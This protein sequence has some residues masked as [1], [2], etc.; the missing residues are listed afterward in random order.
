MSDKTT[1]Y[2]FEK[3]FRAIDPKTLLSFF[4]VDSFSDWIQSQGFDQLEPGTIMKVQQERLEALA[5][6]NEAAVTFYRTQLER[7]AQLFD[8]VMQ[9]AWARPRQEDVSEEAKASRNNFDLQNA[10]VETAIKLMQRYSEETAFA[11]QEAYQKVS[12]EF[13]ASL[14]SSAKP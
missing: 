12:A 2:D 9:A 5:K 1:A 13:Q 10:A 4:R 8:D 6:A 7:Q 11:A 14:K 3:A